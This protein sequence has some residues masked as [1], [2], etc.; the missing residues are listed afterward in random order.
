M[1]YNEITSALKNVGYI[2]TKEI[3]YAAMGCINDGSPLLIE[4]QPGSGKTE[5]SKAISKIT[6]Y[7][8][9]RVQFYEGLTADKILYDYNY[10]RQ[11]LTIEAL[12]P[13]LEKKLQK[14]DINESIDIVKDIDFFGEDFLIERPILKSITSPTRCVL[15]LD[16]IDKSSEEIEYTLLEFLDEFS[17]SI[18]QYKTIVCPEELRPIVILTSNNYRELS[19]ALRRR[20]NYLY[21]KP[22]T[23]KEIEEIL[24]QKAAVNEDLARSIAECVDKIQS[25]NLKQSPSISEF[26]GW[27]KFLMNNISDKDF[28]ADTVNFSIRY[29][30][31]NKADKEKLDSINIS[32]IIIG[33]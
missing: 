8:L 29:L 14:K 5:L 28:S 9:Y 17:I 22:K 26:I 10:Q 19:D 24:I 27:A 31:K 7:P 13:S 2:P 15:L 23:A 30:V 21:I 33:S 12:K 3:A 1:N 20:C 18:P 25:L 4:G 16:E 32:K 11:L 6:G